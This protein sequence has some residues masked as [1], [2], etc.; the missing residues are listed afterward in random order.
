MFLSDANKIVIP[1]TSINGKSKYRRPVDDDDTED[2][3][4]YPDLCR[5]SLCYRGKRWYKGKFYCAFTKKD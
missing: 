2:H 1:C 3:G 5:Y 4:G